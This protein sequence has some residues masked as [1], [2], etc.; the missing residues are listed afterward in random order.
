[1]KFQKIITRDTSSL[2]WLFNNFSR[3][4]WISKE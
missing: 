4:E 2:A 3:R 1:M